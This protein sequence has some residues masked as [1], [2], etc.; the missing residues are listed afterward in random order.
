MIAYVSMRQL[1][2]GMFDMLL[3]TTH[4]EKNPAQ[5]YS[6]LVKNILQ[7]ICPKTKFSPLGLGTWKG[8]MLAITVT[9]GQKY[10]PPTC[11]LGLKR[12]DC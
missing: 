5:L 9:C 11:S 7:L 6:T 4:A 3:H 1:N 12:A 2:F 10:L 8:M